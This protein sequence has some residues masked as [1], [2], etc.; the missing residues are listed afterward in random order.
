M[1]ERKN[2][3][4]SNNIFNL[5]NEIETLFNMS[6][7]QVMSRIDKFLP[8]YQQIKDNDD[9]LFSMLEFLMSFKCKND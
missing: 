1:N 9:T 7:S 5:K 2:P 4:N 6:L 8:S 3:N